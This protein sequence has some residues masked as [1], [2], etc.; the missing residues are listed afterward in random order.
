M[1]LER[2]RRAISEERNEV[3]QTVA[4]IHDEL[5]ECQNGSIHAVSICNLSVS[6]YSCHRRDWSPDESEA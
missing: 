3:N 5:M 4:G 6:T 2:E 1:Q